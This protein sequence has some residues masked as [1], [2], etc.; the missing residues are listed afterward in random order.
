MMYL[1]G[2][3]KNPCDEFQTIKKKLTLKQVLFL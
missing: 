3:K 2:K 1:R